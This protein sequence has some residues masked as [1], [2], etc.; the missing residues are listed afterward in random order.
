MKFQSSPNKQIGFPE[1]RLG[2]FYEENFNA[3]KFMS[4]LKINNDSIPTAPVH[5]VKND[6]K[7]FHHRFQKSDEAN[8]ADDQSN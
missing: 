4:S 2:K 1:E 3:T 7:I 5:E 8:M 6:D